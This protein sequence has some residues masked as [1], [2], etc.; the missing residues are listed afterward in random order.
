MKKQ[1]HLWAIM[2]LT[3]FSISS[4]LVQ[5]RVG[6]TTSSDSSKITTSTT[7]SRSSSTTTKPVKTNSATDSSFANA[8]KANQARAAWQARNQP[9]ALKVNDRR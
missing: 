9:P 8:A 2:L 4:S 7:S 5:A 1:I 6:S 3:I